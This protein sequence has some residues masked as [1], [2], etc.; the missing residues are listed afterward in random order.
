MGASASNV[1]DLRDEPIGEKMN[2]IKLRW[3]VV[4]VLIALFPMAEVHAAPAAGFKIVS[5][6][7]AKK[8]S[9]GKTSGVTSTFKA[10]DHTIYCVVKTNRI[11]KNIK[12][13]FVWTAVNA[14]GIRKNEKFLDKTNTLAKADIIWG[15]AALPHN[16]PTG[17]YRVEVY[18]NGVKMKTLNYSIR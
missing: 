14:K 3:A 7:T 4:A 13:R 6:V 15:S 18:V 2:T 12:A 16:W 9:K 5:A 1:C 8:Y 11:L 17:S 10:S